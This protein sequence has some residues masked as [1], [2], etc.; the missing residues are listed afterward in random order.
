MRIITPIRYNK[1][2]LYYSPKTKSHSTLSYQRI[3]STIHVYSKLRFGLTYSNVISC[4]FRRTSRHQLNPWTGYVGLRSANFEWLYMFLGCHVIPLPL[5][6]T[7][8][9][10]QF[11]RRSFVA[12]IRP[13][14]IRIIR[15][16]RNIRQ[17]KF[18]RWFLL[19]HFH[20][21]C[22]WEYASYRWFIWMYGPTGDLHYIITH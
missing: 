7:I 16:D 9:C 22:R 13:K 6:D 5:V 2:K 10:V 14:S 4:A 21:R 1:S 3:N 19:Y 18:E 12:F 8:H 20:S 11:R 15:I 17:Y